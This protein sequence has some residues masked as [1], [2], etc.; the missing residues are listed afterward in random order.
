MSQTKSFLFAGASSA[1][2][3]KAAEI[4]RNEGYRVI[5]IS[6]N[7]CSIDYD[8]FHV[9]QGYE[10]NNLPNIEGPLAGIVYF[11]G[12]ITL[13]P[14]A[15]ISSDEFMQDMSV[16]AFGAVYFIQQYLNQ[17]KLSDE[18]SI[19]LFS[20]VAV[21]TGMPFHSSVALAKGAIE[22]LIP[23]LAAELAPKIR[24]NAIAPSLTNSSLSER[25]LNTTEKQAAAQQRN[26]M[27]KIGTPEELANAVCFLL[28]S[29]S[30]WITGQIFA[31]DGGMSNLK[32]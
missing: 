3:R 23:A 18:G 29:R 1:I 21:K 26:P 7:D 15:R 12:T 13:K 19:V 2:A 4:L 16:N 31:V 28:T 14:F 24:V 27:K 6:R 22:G 32:L 5:G 11:P 9:V 8:E 20:T 25:F 17:L 10:K 30:S